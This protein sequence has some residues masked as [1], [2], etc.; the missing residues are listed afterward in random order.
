LRDH[1]ESTLATRRHVGQLLDIAPA[2]AAEWVVQL[3]NGTQP[4][5]LRRIIGRVRRARLRWLRAPLLGLHWANE[6]LELW[7]WPPGA[8][9]EPGAKMHARVA[10]RDRRVLLVSRL[11]LTQSRTAANIGAGVLVTGGSAPR[12][13]AEHVANLTTSGVLVRLV[14]TEARVRARP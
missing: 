1:S 8:G 14:A 12:R 4:L 13:A 9:P 5:Q 6:I 3:G 2:D 7:R 10:V 11:N